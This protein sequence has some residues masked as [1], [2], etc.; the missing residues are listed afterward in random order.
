MWNV[1]I[2]SECSKSGKCYCHRSGTSILDYVYEYIFVCGSCGHTKTIKA[3]GGCWSNSTP[4]CPF[5]NKAYDAHQD[6]PEK[7]TNPKKSP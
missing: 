1:V 5:C 3:E 4:K 7:I 2:C 6:L